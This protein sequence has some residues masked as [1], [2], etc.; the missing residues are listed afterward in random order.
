MLLTNQGYSFRVARL[1]D[2]NQL[3]SC[4]TL[5]AEKKMHTILDALSHCFAG[6]GPSHRATTVSVICCL[7][8]R[9]YTEVLYT[10]RLLPSRG[11]PTDKRYFQG[12]LF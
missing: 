4:H 11:V 2:R 7:E 9:M 8:K 5:R 3:S 6:L 10:S 12:T 1:C